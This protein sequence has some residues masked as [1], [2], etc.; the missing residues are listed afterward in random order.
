MGKPRNKQ[1]NGRPDREFEQRVV[2]LARVTRVMAGGKRMRFRACVAIGDKK[3]QCGMGLAKG[4][5]VSIAIN[6]A[7]NRAR[8]N[9]IKVAIIKNTV[10]HKMY[11]KQKAAK[12]LI[13]PAP[14]GTGVKAGGPVRVVLELAGVPNVVAKIMGTN[15]KI[16]NV[17]CLLTM[18]STFKVKGKAVKET[19]TKVD[20]SETSTA[21]SADTKTK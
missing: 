10:P 14:E 12:I 16:N 8:K 5:D 15:N 13:K 9:L 17:R 6:K 19:A 7:A 18:L 4:A 1:N 20:V 3:G 11:L 21:K 2:D